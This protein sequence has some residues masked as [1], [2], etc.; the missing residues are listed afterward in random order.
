MDTKNGY[1][2]KIV[3]TIAPPTHN[4]NLSKLANFVVETLMLQC[5]VVIG[6]SLNP[7]RRPVNL[8]LLLLQEPINNLLTRESAVIK[9][10]VMEKMETIVHNTENYVYLVKIIVKMLMLD[11]EKVATFDVEP[12]MV[13][14]ALLTGGSQKILHLRRPI[15]NLLLLKVIQTLSRTNF[16]ML[17]GGRRPTP[18]L[19]EIKK[20]NG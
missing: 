12:L 10:V 14:Y 6:V 13:T 2:A 8:L 20:N 9:I 7:R 19:S 3:K 18:R 17:L 4:M 5:A 15:N 11:S 1:L 16:W